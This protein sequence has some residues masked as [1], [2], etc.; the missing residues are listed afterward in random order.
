[1]TIEN[2][3]TTDFGIASRFSIENCLR[4]LMQLEPSPILSDE[5][6]I[7]MGYAITNA[8]ISLETL[9]K[10]YDNVYRRVSPV[11]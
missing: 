6:T 2:F 3:N 4:F 1:M 7:E 9:L 5:Q 11:S 10:E 8:V